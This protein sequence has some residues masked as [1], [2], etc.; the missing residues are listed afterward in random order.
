MS[1]PAAMALRRDGND[2]DGSS[3][4]RVLPESTFTE[5]LSSIRFIP[6]FVQRLST[7]NEYGQSLLHLAVHLRYHQLVWQLVEWGVGL[8]LQD[9]NGF[10]ALHCAYLCEDETS[11]TILKRNGASMILLDA[12]GRLPTDLLVN[13]IA[14]HP[15]AEIV[16]AADSNTTYHC[17]ASLES[18]SGGDIQ[19]HQDEAQRRA[20]Y[21]TAGEQVMEGINSATDGDPLEGNEYDLGERAQMPTTPENSNNR[22]DII[23][24]SKPTPV[25]VTNDFPSI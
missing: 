13:P 8:D 10:T 12:L 2:T 15:D 5:V 25:G 16:E 19:G 20:E 6:D 11:V 17:R 3:S 9:Y 18:S 4:T 23:E 22:P 21:S 7:V 24:V 1:T 14:A